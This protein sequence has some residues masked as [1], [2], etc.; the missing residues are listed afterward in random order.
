MIQG[1]LLSQE[2]NG[3]TQAAR[4]D[5]GFLSGYLPYLLILFCLALLLFLGTFMGLVRTWNIDANYSHG[6]LVLPISI[7]LACRYLRQVDFPCQGQAA[8]GC[9]TAGVGCQLHLVTL[10]VVW[11]LLDFLALALILYGTAIVVGGRRWAAGLTFPILFLSFMFPLPVTW[12]NFTSVWLQD[13]VSRVSGQVLEIFVVCHQRGNTIYLA[14]ASEPI[15]VAQ[16]CSGLRQLVAFVALAALVGYLSNRGWRFGLLMIMAA[17][18]VAILSNVLR[19]LLMAVAVRYLGSQSVSGWL[20]DVPA[21]VT[22]PVGLLLFFLI[23]RAV[24][25]WFSPRKVEGAP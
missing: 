15:Y 25:Q 16:E 18:P 2:S 1:N 12:T 10:I 3:S 14:G 17:V 5:A 6:Y 4:P 9:L 8:L 7:W 21:V 23:S 24:G 11:P 19:V 13:W 20:H 22:L